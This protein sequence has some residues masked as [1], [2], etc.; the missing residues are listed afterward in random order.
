MKKDLNYYMSLHYKIEL[1]QIPDS[2][3]GGYTARLPEMGRLAIVGDGDTIEEAVKSLRENMKDRFREYLEKGLP[4][5]EP[6]QE[7]EFS[8]K[9]VLR[10]PPKLHMKLSKLAKEN[11]QSLNQYIASKLEAFV[12]VKDALNEYQRIQKLRVEQLRAALETDSSAKLL[13]FIMQAANE[14]RESALSSGYYDLLSSKLLTIN[15]SSRP[16]LPSLTPTENKQKELEQGIIDSS[17]DIY[18]W[19]TYER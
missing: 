7:E 4:I 17:K 16:P 14:Q 11:G 10:I 19:L 5:P 8:G 1:L 3:G 12:S 15:D 6:A 2:E 9:F 13:A 18:L